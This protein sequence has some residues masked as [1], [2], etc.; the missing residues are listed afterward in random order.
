MKKKVGKSKGKSSEL[1]ENDA[2][3]IAKKKK[4]TNKSKKGKPANAN[5]KTV[6]PN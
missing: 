4:P 1:D 2:S 5:S 6:L 3:V